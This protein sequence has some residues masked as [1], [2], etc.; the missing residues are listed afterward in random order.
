[1]EA[2]ASGTPVIAFR[3]PALEEIVEHGR[4]GSLVDAA[5]DLPNALRRLSELS[6]EA[7]RASAVARC[8]VAPMK[9]RYL[10]AY[11]GLTHPQ[12]A[13]RS[14]VTSPTAAATPIR[15]TPLTSAGDLEQLVEPWRE[16]ANGCPWSTPFQTPEWLLP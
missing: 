10:S 12:H 8:S 4:T 9:E 5:E 15:A 3:G 14:L 2:L 13:R 1:M 11:C 7:C 6:R 16:L